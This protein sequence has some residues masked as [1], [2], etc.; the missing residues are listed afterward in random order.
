MYGGDDFKAHPQ[1]RRDKTHS[2]HEEGSK[3]RVRLKQ[4]KE[5]TRGDLSHLVHMDVKTLNT[6]PNTSEQN[7]FTAPANT[8]THPDT[9]ASGR[10]ESTSLKALRSSGCLIFIYSWG[11]AIGLRRIIFPSL[12]PAAPL[13][14]GLRDGEAQ[15]LA[16]HLLP[17]PAR[18]THA[19]TR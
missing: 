18:V 14:S 2:Q 6:S 17:F 12:H 9:V 10:E 5:C 3:Q 7:T 4:G 11:L 15:T 13:R 19:A 8:Q 1:T 16:A